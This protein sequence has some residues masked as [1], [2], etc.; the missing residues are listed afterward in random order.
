MCLTVLIPYVS[1]YQGM[2]REDAILSLLLVQL[3]VNSAEILPETMMYI[4]V[5]NPLS[6]LLPYTAVG[7]LSIGLTLPCECT[8]LHMASSTVLRYDAIHFATILV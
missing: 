2:M 1:E 4:A 3:S 7:L 8:T 6:V 5:L